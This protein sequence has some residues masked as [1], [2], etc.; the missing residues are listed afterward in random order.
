LLPLGMSRRDL[1]M[2]RTVIPST[3]RVTI[4]DIAMR[5]RNAFSCA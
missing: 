2:S 1:G 4:S 3:W 5:A